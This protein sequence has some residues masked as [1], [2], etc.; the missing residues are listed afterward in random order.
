MDRLHL[1]LISDS[2]G[3]T[4]ENIAKAAIAQF[5]DVEVV[6]H[7]WPMVRSESHLDRIM[8]EVEAS[9]GMILFTLVNGELR[10]SLERRAG[11]QGLPLVPAL[12]AVTDALSRMLGQ[13]AKARPGRQHALD[14]AYFARVD[15]IQFTVAHDD[16]IGW[17]NWEKADIILAGVSRTSKT[18]TSIYLANRG[19][20]T[21][22]IPIVPESPPPTALFSLKRPLV[23]GLTTSLDRLV[24]V[25]RNRLLSLNQAPE[26]SYVDDARVKAEIAYARRLFADNDWP[27]IDVTRR[28]IEET[29]AA[30]IK[31]VE[32]RGGRPA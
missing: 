26:T 15:A 11:A 19:Y 12:D 10:A 28:S 22:N 6:R 14:A 18:P 25:R 9:P 4:L 29:A 24:Q 23:V 2:T 16:G 17:E 8:A 3:E 13:E 7:F 21:A 30:V 31:L 20:K 1:H 32:D 5:D 27:V